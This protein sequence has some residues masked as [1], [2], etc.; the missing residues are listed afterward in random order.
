[1]QVADE[2]FVMDQGRV[3]MGGQPATVMHHPEVVRVYIGQ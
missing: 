2:V 1:V 3:I